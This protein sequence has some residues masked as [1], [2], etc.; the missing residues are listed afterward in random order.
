MVL[1][2][3]LTPSLMGVPLAGAVDTPRPN[4]L[5][6]I[7]AQFGA[8][9]S[10]AATQG[11]VNIPFGNADTSGNPVVVKVHAQ[12]SNEFGDAIAYTYWS[13]G[14]W[15]VFNRY[16]QTYNCEYKRNSSNWSTHA[17]GIAMDVAIIPNP[18]FYTTWNGTGANW[19]NYGWLLPFKF[20]DPA[21][22]NLYW[23]LNF[24]DSQHFQYATGY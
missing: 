22:G 10:P 3:A 18:A 8:P 5:S 13:A 6:A 20:T 16:N 2:V 12:L 23:G 1:A 15:L 17:C 14:T 9:C 19:V 7:N 11:S 21:I 4:G 24:G